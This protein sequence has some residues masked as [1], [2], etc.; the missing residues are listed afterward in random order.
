MTYTSVHAFKGL[1]NKVVVVTDLDL[2]S[3]PAGRSLFYTAL[4]RATDAVHV[5][6]RDE[7]MHRIL[8]WSR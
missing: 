6:C 3:T 5:L 2:S 1:E 4:T 7:D 8:N